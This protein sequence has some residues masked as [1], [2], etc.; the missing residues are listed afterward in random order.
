MG[1]V[2]ESGGYGAR[3]LKGVLEMGIRSILVG[4]ALALL[5]L[6]AGATAATAAETEVRVGG[7]MN[8]WIGQTNASENDAPDEFGEP[9]PPHE[10]FCDGSVSLVPGPATPPLGR[11][12]AELRTGNGT[13]GGECAA[14]IRNSLY[15]GKKLSELATLE[16]STYLQEHAVNEQQDTFLTLFV[17][18][19]GRS[20]GA[21]DDELFF[22]PP[23]QSHASGNPSLPEQGPVELGKW[24]TWNAAAGGWWDNNEELGAPGTGVQALSK[25]V[26]AHP[27]AVIV[28]S[29]RGGGVRVAVG[30]AEEDAKFV[31]YV[32]NFT[33]GFGAPPTTYNF[34]PTPP[35]AIIKSPP[36]GGAYTKGASVATEFSCE[37]SPEEPGFEF[38]E[39]GIEPGSPIASCKDSHGV[40]GNLGT[41]ALETGALGKVSYSVTAKSED[42]EEATAEISYRVVEAPAVV[43]GMASMVTETEA[44]LKGTVN[45]NETNVSDCR[46]EYGISMSYGS[47]APCSTSP[48][49]GPSPVPVSASVTGLAPGTTF[50]FRI[51]ATNSAGT[52]HGSDQSFKTVATPP[53]PTVTRISPKRGPT[54]GGT[55]VT[56]TG[57]NLAGATEVK[58]G[59]YKATGVIVYSPTSITVTSPAGMVG[60]VHVS[61]TTPGGTS[62]V[63]GKAA[64]K[65]RF[66]YVKVRM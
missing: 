2:R 29:S 42:G 58:F 4:A 23:Y 36:T 66:G 40:E 10:S 14:Q 65:T 49:S 8:G 31:S 45:P 46:F 12:S 35:T 54:T 55:S 62:P 59:S 26:E 5:L 52:S 61:V 18:N 11:G 33:I 38:G 15:A 56:I 21:V 60:T 43:T 50:H 47:S 57:T 1:A 28:N 51:V 41:G 3:N 30:E 9:L 32:D 19:E 16:Y 22:E 63:S 6:L 44:T 20:H 27:E 48:G 34:E 53:P 17:N 37:P 24:Q 13:T 64:M 7:H 25:Y 39:A